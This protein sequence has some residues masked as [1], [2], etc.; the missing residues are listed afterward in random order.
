MILSTKRKQ[1]QKVVQKAEI[2]IKTR[3]KV[4]AEISVKEENSRLMTK[5]LN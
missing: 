1:N 2:E 5:I 4:K 3:A